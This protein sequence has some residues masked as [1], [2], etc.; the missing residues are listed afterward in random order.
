MAP[1][2]TFPKQR[3]LGRCITYAAKFAAIGALGF[4]AIAVVYV[5]L[6]L[7]QFRSSGHN[8]LDDLRFVIL[9]FVLV[10][11]LSGATIGTIVGVAAALL[12]SGGPK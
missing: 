9:S 6:D 7:W 12:R 3:T 5:L 8:P 2:A 11:V 10:A 1:E 4:G